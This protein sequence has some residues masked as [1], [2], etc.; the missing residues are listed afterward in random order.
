ME[1]RYSVCFILY[2]VFLDLG[3]GLLLAVCVAAFL[4][5]QPIYSL[6]TLLL[7]TFFSILF[8][9][10]FDSMQKRIENEHRNR[11]GGYYART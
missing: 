11:N 7:L 3:K 10:L 5:K 8:S 6:A 1:L 4:T 9:M 2:I